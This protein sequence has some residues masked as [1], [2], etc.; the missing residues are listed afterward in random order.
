VCVFVRACVRALAHGC[1][2]ARVCACACGHAG[3]RAR[4]GV[5]LRVFFFFA[6][7]DNACR[8]TGR[9]DDDLYGCS[10]FGHECL[11]FCSDET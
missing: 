2:C 6:P 11:I 10:Y 3:A 4:V 7:R 5:R 8:G 9:R 1:V